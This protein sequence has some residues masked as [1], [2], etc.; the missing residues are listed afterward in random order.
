[1]SDG[2][3]DT[4]TRRGDRNCA[5]GR[6]HSGCNR[7]TIGSSGEH[8][9]ATV[10]SYIKT[11]TRERNAHEV[12]ADRT[13]RREGGVRASGRRTDE[14]I[15]VEF[16][17]VN[18]HLVTGEIDVVARSNRLNRGSIGAA[19]GAGAGNR[20]GRGRGA[21]KAEG[22]IDAEEA[23]GLSNRGSVES[24][25]VDL[26]GLRDHNTRGIQ[27]VDITVGDNTTVDRRCHAAAHTVEHRIGRA[28]EEIVQHIALID[29][30][31]TR[32]KCLPGKN[33]LVGCGDI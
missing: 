25:S 12:N 2:A 11:T 19:R 4:I 23:A 16:T 27:N 14:E 32:T 24:A 13:G 3:I 7:Q 28:G 5:G 8:N 31:S 21:S 1:L 9:I 22:A 15:T 30:A 29:R 17:T 20:D 18:I 33:G 26:R 6:S 10:G